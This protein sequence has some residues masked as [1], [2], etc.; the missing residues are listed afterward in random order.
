M[1]S[2]E[3]RRFTAGEEGD[4]ATLAHALGMPYHVAGDFGKV[5]VA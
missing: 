4:G 3:L 5:I 2:G 1:G